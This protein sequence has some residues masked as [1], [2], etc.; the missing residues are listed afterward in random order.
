M[1]EIFLRKIMMKAILKE[2]GYNPDKDFNSNGTRNGIEH[3][4]NSKVTVSD[5]YEGVKKFFG[6]GNKE[7]GGKW[8]QDTGGLGSTKA[9]SSINDSAKSA[10]GST[11]TA[12]IKAKVDQTF[13][14]GAQKYGTVGDKTATATT[15][16][17]KDAAYDNNKKRIYD[18]ISDKVAAIKAKIAKDK[19]YDNN[20]KKWITSAK[21]K[22][23][24]LLV[25]LKKVKP[26]K[27]KVVTRGSVTTI[28]TGGYSGHGG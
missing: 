11:W 7:S 16:V 12:T 3:W 19:Y 24:P 2:A 17:G 23:V 20:K 14:D 4:Y 25:Y 13:E 6:Y 5:I 15:K 26:Y 8:K 1:K 10:G 28:D 18:S 22:N 9:V 21:G 27:V